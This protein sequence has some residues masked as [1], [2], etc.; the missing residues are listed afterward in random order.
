MKRG[1][2]QFL[3]IEINSINERGYDYQKYVKNTTLGESNIY[4]S[5][6]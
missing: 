1:D 5:C 6:N 3:I 4:S 2:F